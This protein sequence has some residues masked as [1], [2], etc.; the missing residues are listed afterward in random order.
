MLLCLRMELNLCTKHVPFNCRK[1]PPPCSHA[2][3]G[4]QPQLVVKAVEELAR[5]HSSQVGMFL[6]Q[7]PIPNQLALMFPCPAN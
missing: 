4:H 5:G 7:C 6:Q 1:P 2:D 3:S